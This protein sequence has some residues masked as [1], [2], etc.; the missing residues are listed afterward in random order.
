MRL[1][2]LLILVAALVQFSYAAQV[3]SAQNYDWDDNVFYMPTEIIAFDKSTNKEYPLD[4]ATFAKVREYVGKPGPYPFQNDDK[5]LPLARLEFR[6][7][8]K[9]P[10]LG[11][12][13][14]FRD[15]TTMNYFKRDI[16]RALQ[17]DPKKSSWKGPAWSAFV[18]SL[19]QPESARWTTIIT[20]R[21]HSA[22]AIYEGMKVLHSKG[23]IKYLPTVDHLYAVTGPTFGGSPDSP[24]N[25]KVKVMEQLLDRTEEMAVREKTKIEWSF[26]DDDFGNIKAARDHFNAVI[27]SNPTR[28]QDA[29]I[30]LYFTGKNNPSEKPHAIE[31][32]KNR[33]YNEPL[34]REYNK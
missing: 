13:R 30:S 9:H 32:R 33:S 11:S 1:A 7:D 16:I 24:S 21:G 29:D 5:I 26:S 12:Y 4:T 6:D 34:P 23:L 17:R 22:K 28:W 27:Q 8:S 20:A 25:L 18:A 2:R 10:E 3:T 19:S 31:L 15:G 14:Y